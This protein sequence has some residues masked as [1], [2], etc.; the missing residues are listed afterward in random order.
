MLVTFKFRKRFYDELDLNFKIIKANLATFKFLNKSYTEII[1]KACYKL[2]HGIDKPPKECPLNIVKKSKKYEEAECYLSEKDI[3]LQVSS[4]PVFDKKGRMIRIAHIIRDITAFRK[5]EASLR[6]SGGRFR[7]V[8]DYANHSIQVMDST[9]RKILM[10]NKTLCEMLGYSKEE[11]KKL[12]AEE[13]YPQKDVA[14]IMQIFKKL[15][16]EEMQIAKAIPLLKKDGNIFYADV[17][18]APFTMGGKTYLMGIFRDTAEKKS[19]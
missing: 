11:L 10:A 9:E 1:G 17:S 19:V 18:A 3:W 16:R 14:S 6:E 8:F 12:K 2:I 15:L 13:I 4:A 5:T 7:A